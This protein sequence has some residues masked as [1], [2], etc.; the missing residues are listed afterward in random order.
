MPFW[1]HAGASISAWLGDAQ[2]SLDST[3]L[4]SWPCPQDDAYLD[5]RCDGQHGASIRLQGM[6]SFRALDL[7][8]AVGGG[9]GL[10][11]AAAEGEQ[12]PG[13]QRRRE[14][15]RHG[16]LQVAGWAAVDPAARQVAAEGAYFG[17]RLFKASILQLS[18]TGS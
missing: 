13:E 7:L 10:G 17:T 4:V 14:G 16:H 18:C 9:V 3:C 12:A 5:V 15:R 11:V 6:G 2:C 8:H 1:V